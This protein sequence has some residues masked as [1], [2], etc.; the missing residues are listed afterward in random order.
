MKEAPSQHQPA[1]VLQ[2]K[3][4]LKC[5]IVTDSTASYLLAGKPASRLE[6]AGQ[7]ANS[8]EKGTLKN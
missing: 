1:S 8:S 4:A 5:V 2:S 3:P 6:P 7:L